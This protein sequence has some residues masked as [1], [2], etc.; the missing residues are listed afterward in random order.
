MLKAAHPQPDEDVF[1]D[2]EDDAPVRVRRPMPWLRIAILS[3]A[4][5][6][7]LVHL[8]QNAERTAV[9]DGPREV[10][11]AVLTAPPPAWRILARPTPLFGFEPSSVP[12][13]L[14]ARE[15]SGGEREDT[16]TLGSL[17]DRVFGRITLTRGGEARPRSLF[18]DTVRRAAEAGLSVARNAP[19]RTLSTKFG[20]VEAAAMT[21][22]GPAEQGCQVF[23]W[24]DPGHESGLGLHGWLCGG[25]AEPADDHRVACFVDRLTLVN[26]ADPALKALFRDAEARRAASCG[27]DPRTASAE[28]A[29]PIRR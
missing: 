27:S 17:G 4:I 11:S 29:A 24:S 15:R 18:V 22:A 12:A 6:A 3:G 19:S 25:E 26:E 20:P 7:G 13:G 28:P 23:R 9:P 21:L 5:V 16:L 1:D 14:Q 8:A 10:P 2:V